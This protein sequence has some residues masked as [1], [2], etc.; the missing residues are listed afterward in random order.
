MFICPLPGG[1]S[2]NFFYVG[3]SLLSSPLESSQFGYCDR[4]SRRMVHGEYYPLLLLHGGHGHLWAAHG[5]HCHCLSSFLFR[6]VSTNNH[7]AS[8]RT[9][10]YMTSTLESHNTN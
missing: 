6:Q 7:F 4:P 9:T 10:V 1:R 3:V 5:G 8:Y 2:W